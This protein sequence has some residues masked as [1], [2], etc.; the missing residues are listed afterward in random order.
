M[1]KGGRV[2]VATKT[3]AVTCD[4]CV[5][6]RAGMN[7]AEGFDFDLVESGSKK[8]HAEIESESTSAVLFVIGAHVL[9]FPRADGLIG[10]HV[11]CRRRNDAGDAGRVLGHFPAVETG[12]CSKPTLR[13]NMAAMPST[14][15]PSRAT[16]GIKR[17]RFQD[18]L[19]SDHAL[20]AELRSSFTGAV[21]E[22]ETQDVS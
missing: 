1:Q 4:C 10:L 2:D 9:P 19:A 6:L 21:R 12:F 11:L 13:F 3:S 17:G 16:T 14:C 7:V 22:A 20:A 15:A 8:L 18:L 5:A